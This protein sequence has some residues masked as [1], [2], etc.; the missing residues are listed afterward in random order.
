MRISMAILN[1]RIVT[2][3]ETT[4]SYKT[5]RLIL[6]DQ[7]NGSHSWFKINQP[8]TLYIIAELKQEATYTKHHKQKI[9]VF[10]AAM[11]QFAQTLQ[12]TGHHVT[13]LTLDDTK[14]FKDLPALMTHLC[15]LHQIEQF[16]YQLPDEYRLRQQLEDFCN[17]LSIVS[18]AAGSEHFYLPDN[19]INLYFKKGKRHRLE[20]FYRKMRKRFNVLMDDNL[21]TGGEWNYD[22]N[23]RNKL[24]P[25][26]LV[27][28]PAP[29]MFAN[30]ITEILARIE[31]HDIKTI[32]YATDEV[33]WPINHEQATELLMFF[34][35]TCLPRFGKFQDSMTGKLAL[36]GEDRGWSLYHSRISFA[37]NCKILSPKQVID[38]A[39]S[40]FHESNGEIDIAQIEGFV[41]QIIGWREFVRGI[42]WANMPDYAQLNNLSATRALPSWFWN[43]KTDMNCLHHAIKQSLEF[44]YA[45]HI[46][47]LMVTGNFCLLTGIQPDQVDDWYLG[48][49]IDAIEWVEMPNT[50]GMSQFA[51][52]GIVGSKA[53]AASGNY[54]KKMS[55][56]CS[57]CSYQVNEIDTENACPLNSLYWNFM[58]KNQ[59]TMATNPR[60]KMVYSNWLKKPDSQKKSILNKAQYYL[61]NIEKL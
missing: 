8:N 25:A 20:N 54:I 40:S 15:K 53:Y 57:D 52:G 49:Y 43:A 30:D 1:Q 11:E 24:K 42:Y 4:K 22:Q 9:A 48:I 37:L 14:A 34:C 26:D 29:L 19:E 44:S 16:E 31:R 5:L 55:D 39:I 46:Q 2:M 17:N 45:H 51:D 12:Q 59:A 33:L 35:Q 18:Q 38:T 10:F 58:E 7:L 56:Y 61:D 6:G 47:R 27:E 13:H 41:R 32:G 23:N 3:S 36:F 60:T 50:R 28:I 21:P